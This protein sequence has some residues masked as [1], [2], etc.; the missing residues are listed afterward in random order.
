MQRILP[1]LS[2]S[3]VLNPIEALSVDQCQNSSSS[4]WPAQQLEPSQLCLMK[5]ICSVGHSAWLPQQ[6]CG[7]DPAI[8]IPDVHFL[9]VDVVKALTEIFPTGGPPADVILKDIKAGEALLHVIGGVLLPTSLVRHP[10][11]LS[12]SAA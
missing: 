4:M 1:I 8:A 5:C 2:D 10:L 11:G 12:R 7:S 3:R 9:Q 6:A